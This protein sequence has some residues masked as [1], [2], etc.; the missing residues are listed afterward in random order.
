[1]NNPYPPATGRIDDRTSVGASQAFLVHAFAWMFAGLLLT[2]GVAAVV[3]SSKTLTTFAADNLLL[4]FIGQLALV[5]VISGAI[6]RLSATAALGLFFVYAG[7]L[8]LTV[9]LI[10]QYYTG[11][12]V[13][14]AFA[15]ASAMFGAAAVYGATT[16]R[17]LAGLG[18]ILFMGLI[19]LI[20]ASVL[21]L[22]LHSDG[23]SWGISIVGV[24][25]FTAL[26]AFDVQRIQSGTLVAQLGSV[27]KAA[28]IGALRLYL[29]FINL[30]LFMLRLMGGRR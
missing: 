24:V 4:L 11:A 6:N 15:S 2:A 10:V 20:V 8:G 22:F 13:V 1:M 19:G 3:Q 29:D 14:V 16:R 17:S 18:G 9:G 7:T 25:I 23:V 5:V 28:V 12:S 21:N 30:F 26:T 27:E